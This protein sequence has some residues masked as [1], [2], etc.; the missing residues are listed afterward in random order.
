M[1]P[2]ICSTSSNVHLHSCRRL[3][4]F[5][6]A[7]IYMAI[8][9]KDNTSRIVICFHRR[10]RKQEV[11]FL[12]ET[13][14]L[15]LSMYNDRLDIVEQVVEYYKNIHLRYLIIALVQVLF[16]SIVM[17]CTSFFKFTL[18]STGFRFGE[19]FG[20]NITVNQCNWL[21]M[22]CLVLLD[23]TGIKWL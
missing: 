4:I 17:V 3:D 10:A 11:R 5:S 20:R 9:A 6:T 13:Q 1:S 15:C 2:K 7:T 16:C 14:I 18:V 12:P 23:Q 8:Q 22:N 21:F 19:R